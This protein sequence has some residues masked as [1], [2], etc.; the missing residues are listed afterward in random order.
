MKIGNTANEQICAKEVKQK[1][2]KATG[3]TWVNKGSYGKCWAEF[4]DDIRIHGGYRA[5]LFKGNTLSIFV[6]N[7]IW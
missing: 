6:I 5:C 3:A 4:G 2:P 1:M 7:G